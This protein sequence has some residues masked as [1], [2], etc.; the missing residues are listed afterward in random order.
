MRR[1]YEVFLW[2]LEVIGRGTF[3]Q[4]RHSLAAGG[5]AEAATVWH[6][7]GHGF[8]NDPFNTICCTGEHGEANDD[9]SCLGT[10]ACAKLKAACSQA[11]GVYQDDGVVGHCYGDS[12]GG[13]QLITPPP[14]CSCSR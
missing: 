11:G 4:G 9:C 10:A 8:D 1:P 7:Q 13:G 3:A 6:C 5:S 14:P 2:E 12:P